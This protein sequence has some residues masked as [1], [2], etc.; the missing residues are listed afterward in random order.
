M[1]LLLCAFCAFGCESHDQSGTGDTREGTTTGAAQ[2]PVSADDL[3]MFAGRKW[4]LVGPCRDTGDIFRP[5]M[6]AVYYTTNDDNIRLVELIVKE[7][8][9]LK[10]GVFSRIL[11]V[12]RDENGQWISDGPRADWDLDGSRSESEYVNGKIHGTQR[13]WYPNGQ[14]HIERE[15]AY[16]K[17]HGRDRGWYPSGKPQYDCQNIDGKEV[18]GNAWGEDGRPL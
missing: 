8:P 13:A 16:G 10:E 6:T 18:S 5:S 11:S 15:W 3:L 17:V 9:T 12:Q 2:E 7:S 14:L 4:T 1:G